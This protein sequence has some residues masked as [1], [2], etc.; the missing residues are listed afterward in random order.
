MNIQGLDILAALFIVLL[1]QR[2]LRKRP[3]YPFPPGP[4]KWPLIGNLLDLPS[5]YESETYARWGKEL[6]SGIIHIDAAGQ[7]III[8]NSA[9]IATDLFH[10]RSSKYSSRHVY[11][12]LTERWGWLMSNLP[13][14]ETWRERRRLF[15]KH[16]HPT[17]G[18][19][20]HQT[21]S[22]EFIRRILPNLMDTPEKFLDLTRHMIGGITLSIAYGITT[23]TEDDYFVNLAEEAIGII[24]HAT[25]PGT[26]LVDIMP[27]LKYVPQW[28][29]GAGFH[30]EP[31]EATAKDMENG[32][33]KPSF[34]ATCLNEV[35]EK[36]QAEKKH[37][38][39]VIKDTAAMSFT[40]GADT[41]VS[42]MWSFILAMVC[43]PDV[44]RKV[45]VEI[46]TVVGRD[47]LPEFYDEENMPYLAAT[48]REVLRWKPVAPIAIPHLVTEDDVYDNYFIQKNSTVIGNVWAMLQD[49]DEY[50]NPER[51]D[52]ERYLRNGKLDLSDVR[53]PL[54]ASFG[55][56]RRECPG[57]QIAMSTLWI[58]AATMLSVFNIT[59]VRD[60][61]GK[62]EEIDTGYSSGIVNHANPF[63]ANFI[64]RSKEAEIMARSAAEQVGIH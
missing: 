13:Y 15:T 5:K 53:D 17:A 35:E 1:L 12:Q 19:T 36:D 50:P 21:R 24:N 60:K 48:L 20:V 45:Q 55:F 6:N 7:N 32:T 23:K 4:K 64:P 41:T 27:F 9:K 2:L 44:Q 42:A 56:G 37:V 10:K 43:H 51:F 29:P 58:T 61:N 40:A 47:R 11:H 34:V 39:R 18:T 63:K 30:G 33:A 3:L 46:D 22:M 54:D 26:F 16:F 52:P 59:N 28:V 8:V 14:G 57:R 25:V 62:E 49:E 31:F 38:I